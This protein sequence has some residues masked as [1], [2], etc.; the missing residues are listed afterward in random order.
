MVCTGSE[1]LLQRERCEWDGLVLQ[2]SGRFA[3]HREHVL[4]AVSDTIGVPQSSAIVSACCIYI[5][6][7]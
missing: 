3:H 2:T 4:Q 7:L 5:Y 6:N 1:Q